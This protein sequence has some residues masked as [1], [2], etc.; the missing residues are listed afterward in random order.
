MLLI[1]SIIKIVLVTA[2]FISLLVLWYVGRTLAY[3]LSKLQRRW[4]KEDSE[5][6][7]EA[8]GNVTEIIG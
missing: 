4:N 7:P 8:L 2:I 3:F 6:L 1:L 5:K